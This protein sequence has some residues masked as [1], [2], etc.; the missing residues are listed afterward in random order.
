MIISTTL[1]AYCLAIGAVYILIIDILFGWGERFVPSLANFPP[2]LME[3]RTTSWYFSC[4]VIEFIFFVMMP[5]VVYGWFYTVIPFSGF[6]GGMTA[7][8][9]VFFFGM[10]PLAL[11]TL[12]RIKI[13]AVY[14]LYQLVALFFKVLGALAIIGYLYSL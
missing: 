1:L 11:L 14:M 2:H 12:F 3:A 7:G 6:K 10:I 9:Y 8:F 13:P 4:F 5:A